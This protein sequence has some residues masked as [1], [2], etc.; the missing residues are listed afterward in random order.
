MPFS[1]FWPGPTRPNAFQTLISPKRLIISWNYI[2]ISSVL[3]NLR[4][5]V[6]EAMQ[7]IFREIWC[8]KKIIE[9]F[10]TYISKT[11]GNIWNFTGLILL[12]VLC[13]TTF[14]II[15]FSQKLNRNMEKFIFVILWPKKLNFHFFPLKFL[16]QRY[17]KLILKTKKIRWKWYNREVS[18]IIIEFYKNFQVPQ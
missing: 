14:T 13:S 15:I 11:T 4:Y 3:I 17:D 12:K 6:F 2:N 16:F 5:Q 8:N 10:F 1:Q 7:K 9:Q 18:K